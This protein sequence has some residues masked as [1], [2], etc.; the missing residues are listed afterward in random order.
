[1]ITAEPRIFRAMAFPGGW[2]RE[3]SALAERILA[4]AGDEPIVI[5]AFSNAGFWTYAAMLRVLARDPRG[6]A[7]RDRISAVVID[8]APGFPERLEAGF[9]ARYSAMAVTPILLRAMK[10]EPEL[11][12]PLLDLP[13][14][15]FMRLWFHASPRQIRD[16]EQSLEVVRGTG[17]W[18]LL[19]LYSSADTLV[20]HEYV[21][22]FVASLAAR[23]RDVTS[24]CWDDSE[25]V[26]HMLKHRNAYFRAIDVLLARAV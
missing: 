9:T 17:E 20:S 22:P 8:S 11:S 14:R 15:A 3:G 26:R 2:A 24:I 25:H 4:S 7:V 19:F 10:R 21:E 5:H 13:L 12:H 1:V 6:R 16:V 18:P 23:G